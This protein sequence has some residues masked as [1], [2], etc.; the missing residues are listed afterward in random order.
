MIDTSQILQKI[1]VKE[2]YLKTEVEKLDI[3]RNKKQAYVSGLPRN[4]RNE[5]FL[6]LVADFGEVESI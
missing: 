6:E 3:K 2:F 4:M 1:A 5:E